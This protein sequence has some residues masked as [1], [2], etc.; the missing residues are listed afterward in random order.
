LL[1]D[2]SNGT[3]CRNAL[4]GK[5]T[6]Y[7]LLNM[8]FGEIKNKLYKQNITTSVPVTCDY[9]TKITQNQNSQQVN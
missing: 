5:P 7:A 2:Y 3:G 1:H 9:L 8:K 6:L 4:W